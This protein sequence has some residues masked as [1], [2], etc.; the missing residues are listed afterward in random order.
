MRSSF[1]NIPR[2]Y[3]QIIDKI[4][5][6]PSEEEQDQYVSNARKLIDSLRKCERIIWVGTGRQ[7]EIA[8]FATRLVKAS[9]KQTFCSSDSSIPYE[10]NINDIVVAL[11]SSGETKR[12]IHYAESAYKP[13]TNST[14]VISITTNPDSTIAKISEKTGGFIVKIPGKSKADDVEYQERQ[15]SGKHEPLTLG[16]TLGELY[17][18]EFILDS[19]GSAV[20]AK[21]VMEFHNEFWSEVS[22]Y[23]PEPEQFER[24]YEMLPKPIDYSERRE[25]RVLPNKTV[26]GGLGLSGVIARAFSIRLAHC[27]GENCER[28]VN[29]YKDTGSIAI[30][31]NDLSL[32]FSGSGQEFWRKSLTPIKKLGG[33]I[34]AITSLPDSPLGEIAD[35]YLEIPGRKI[36]RYKDKIENPPR[37]PEE[38]LFEI[39]SLLAM[40]AFIHSLVK[41]EKISIKAVEGKH[42]QLT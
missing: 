19:I 24:L 35:D 28:L 7:E 21:P 13:I 31:E 17:A 1:S 22:D 10:Y 36:A 29:F 26:I 38:A 6:Y 20:T 23:S 3:R 14:P 42:S 12:T 33:K 15:F 18:L 27:A 25:N 34:F 9:D 16:G 11:S 2:I 4:S 39:R 5:S 37:S 8:N 30:R 32:V 40:E 41:E